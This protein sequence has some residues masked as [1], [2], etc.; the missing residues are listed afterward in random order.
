MPTV[1]IAGASG[2][3]GS[4][5]LD[6]FLDNG[7]AAV[8]LSRRKPE[9]DSDREFE[10]LSVDL[11]DGDAARDALSKLD[12][13]THVVYA[14]LYEKPGLIAGWQEQDQMETNLQ[15]LKNTLEPIVDTNQL[16][17]VSILQGTKAYGIHLHPM[18]IPARERAPRDDHANFYWLQE[19]YLK[20]Q[21][22]QHGFRWSV[23]RPQLIIG[24]TIGAAMNLA[25]VIGAYAAVCKQNGEP[26]GFPGGIAYV[27]EAVDS[28]LCA[29]ALEMMATNPETDGQHYNVTN[30]DVFEWRNLWPALMQQ[31]GVEAGPDNPRSMA[32][33]LPENAEAWD[34]VVREQGLRPNTIEDLLGESHHYADF[35]FAY[36][37]DEPPPAAFVSSIKLRKAGVTDVYDTEET[38]LHWMQWQQDRKILPHF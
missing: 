7:W 23:L 12:G 11:R 35:C 29:A 15:M 8:A 28:R 32:E 37:A 3:V 24:S 13:L 34:A 6:R 5:A 17:N 27:W 31:I 20:E 30:G 22:A 1:L 36:G 2:V 25:P 14:A 16:E 19:D 9:I 18:P 33:Y 4:A 21:A 26:C 38:F 10:H